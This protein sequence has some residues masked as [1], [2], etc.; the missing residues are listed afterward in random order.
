LLAQTSNIGN[1]SRNTFGVVPEL[2]GNIGYAITPRLRLI[3]GYTFI[4]WSS[5]ARAGS[6][7]DTDVNSTLLPNSPN[8][9]S[10][11]LRHPQFVFHEAPFWAQ[12]ISAGLDY[13]W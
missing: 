1:Y 2:A 5:V 8:P 11:D 13:R 9:P 6:Q 12:G 7:I 3:C 10:G 4:Y